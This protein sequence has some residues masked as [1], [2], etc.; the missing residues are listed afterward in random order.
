MG[1][2]QLRLV[3]E[4][5]SKFEVEKLHIAVDNNDEAWFMSDDKAKVE[6]FI[7]NWNSFIKE[8]VFGNYAAIMLAVRNSLL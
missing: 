1:I 4:D 2:N 8:P 7:S 3:E 5:G 6:N